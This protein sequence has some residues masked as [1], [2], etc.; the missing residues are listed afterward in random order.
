MEDT[1]L[2]KNQ[3]SNFSQTS[4]GTGGSGGG[5]GGKSQPRNKVVPIGEEKKA[6][7]S[8][9]EEIYRHVGKGKSEK[10]NRSGRLKQLK[11][12][13]KELSKENIFKEVSS[14]EALQEVRDLILSRDNNLMVAALWDRSLGIFKRDPQ[15][16]L[17][18]LDYKVKDLFFF[19]HLKFTFN[20][21]ETKIIHLFSTRGLCLL[22]VPPTPRH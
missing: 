13:V 1:Q 7:L 11:E 14:L 9:G 10:G 5:T 6:K 19:L 3:G 20:Q 15:T 12:K 8:L 16:G 4:Q 22:F 18:Y 2:L 17:F 21:N